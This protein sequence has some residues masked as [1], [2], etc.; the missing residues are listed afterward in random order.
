MSEFQVRSEQFDLSNPY[1]AMAD[2]FVLFLSSL[3]ALAY[4]PDLVSVKVWGSINLAY[5]LA[6]AQFAVMFATAAARSWWARSVIDPLAAEAR[7]R[8]VTEVA[9]GPND[10]DG[11]RS[12]A[13]R[14]VLPCVPMGFLAGWLGTI[15]THKE[16]DGDHRFDELHTRALTGFGAKVSDRTH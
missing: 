16:P 12:P 13:D 15:A 3:V 7:S 4:F 1:H 9:G 5:L 6:L 14:S 8:L 2:F 11:E 10:S